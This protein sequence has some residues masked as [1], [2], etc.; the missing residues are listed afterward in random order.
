MRVWALGLAGGFLAVAL[1]AP[2]RLAGANL[3]WARFG[4]VLHKLTSP[5]ALGLV[6]FLTFVPIGF[7]IRLFGVDSLRLRKPHTDS[8]WIRRSSGTPVESN[9]RNQ[10]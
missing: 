9:M 1:F 4:N 8:Y 10:F 6:F 5:V 7:V 3:M 2:A